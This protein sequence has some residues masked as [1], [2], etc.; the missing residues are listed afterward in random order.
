VYAACKAGGL[1]IVD[2]SSP[3]APAQIGAYETDGLARGVFVDGGLAYVADGIAGLRIVD[4]SNPASPGEVGFYDT[5]GTT[6][7][8]VVDSVYA[9][10]A[11]GGGGFAVIDVSVPTAPAEIARVP[12]GSLTCGVVVEGRYA[13]VANGD[14]GLRVFYVNDPAHPLEV[15]YFDTADFARKVAVRNETVFLAD[16]DD[17]MYV[18]QFDPPPTPV[19]IQSFTARAGV[20]GVTLE[21]TVHS[22]ERTA[23][24]RVY[25]RGAG[26]TSCACLNPGRLLP[27]QASV[28]HDDGILPDSEYEYVLGITMRNGTEIR[29]V[30]AGV[31]TGPGTLSLGQNYPNPF[32]PSTT[33]SLGLP[34]PQ[35]VSV[36]IFDVEGRLVRRLVDNEVR[37]GLCQVEW[38]GVNDDGLRVGSGVYVYRLEAGKRLLSK[39]MLLLK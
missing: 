34:S 26:E 10:C 6:Y 3:A 16:N 30:P 4:V 17:G 2:V 36:S 25:R 23:G 24:Y 32:N 27:P 13:Y 29:S 9:Y 11:D 33:I 31:R 5:S 20:E 8:V 21:W 14:G 38:D 35:R 28:Y 18:L 22:D 39:K 19:L 37:S 7:E 1:R 12:L 15:G